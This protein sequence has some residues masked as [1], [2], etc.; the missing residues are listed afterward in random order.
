[1]RN[2]AELGLTTSVFFARFVAMRLVEEGFG[3]SIPAAVI[4]VYSAHLTVRGEVSLRAATHL[5]Q[6]PKT[7]TS[8]VSP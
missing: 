6:L 4:R 2:S 1:M 8:A 7:L 3:E 5:Q